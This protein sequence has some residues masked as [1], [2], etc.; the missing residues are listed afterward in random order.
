MRGKWRESG[1]RARDAWWMELNLLKR[2]AVGRGLCRA[3]DRPEWRWTV[4]SVSAALED[5]VTVHR[6]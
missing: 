2:R 3:S 6:R 1:R 5:S 4:V